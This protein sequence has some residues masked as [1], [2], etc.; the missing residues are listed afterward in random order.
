LYFLQE[1]E[2]ASLQI[3]TKDMT[4]A[5]IDS[6]WISG[7]D[8]VGFTSNTGGFDIVATEALTSAVANANSA[9]QTV[10][11]PAKADGTPSGIVA[12]RTGNDVTLAIDESITWIFDCGGAGV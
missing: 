3:I 7:N 5:M 9:V 12:N 10:T 11:A 4:G 2:G 8:Y 1:D 6:Y